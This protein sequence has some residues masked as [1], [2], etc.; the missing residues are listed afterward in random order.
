MQYPLSLKEFPLHLTLY[1]MQLFF[2]LYGFKIHLRA[3]VY[4]PNYKQ[5]L[6]QK[7]PVANKYFSCG[8]MSVNLPALNFF[9][10]F[11]MIWF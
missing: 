2:F 11:P 5:L 9:H 3:I 1:L 10:I 7:S 4:L 8:K 6:T